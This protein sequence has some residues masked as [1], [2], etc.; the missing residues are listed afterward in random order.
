MEDFT[1]MP[2][3]GS[4]QTPTDKSTNEI[5]NETPA[6]NVGVS[7][8]IPTNGDDPVKPIVKTPL[9]NGAI[10]SPEVKDFE[11]GVM[12]DVDTSRSL[13]PMDNIG[14]TSNDLPDP[15]QVATDGTGGHATGMSS[16]T[17]V[18]TKKFNPTLDYNPTFTG[19]IEDMRRQQA[20]NQSGW[21]QAG[22]AILRVGANLLP[23]IG[24][25]VG[26]LFD[27]IESADSAHANEWT[28]AM[29]EIKDNV[30]E[31]LPIYRK[32]PNKTF[33]YTDSAWWFDNGSNV[34]TSGIAFVLIGRMTGGA[35][36]FGLTSATRGAKFGIESIKAINKAGQ[37]ARATT[38]APGTVNV[39]N[40]LSSIGATLAMNQMETKGIQ[41]E[42]FSLAYDKKLRELKADPANINVDDKTLENLA[43]EDA[44]EK[45]VRAGRINRINILLNLSSV[46]ALGKPSAL[47]TRNLLKP[48]SFKRSA[49]R[50]VAEMAQEYA[51]ETI[52]AVATDVSVNE[53]YGIDNYWKSA[54]SE[55]AREQGFFGALGGGFQTGLTSITKRLPTQ[56]NRAYQDAFTEKVKEL[57]ASGTTLTPQ[58]II[59]KANEYAYNTAGKKKISQK[60]A[61]KQAY[62][63]QQRAIEEMKFA[64][65]PDNVRTET[66]I[67]SSIDDMI[68]IAKEITALEADGKYAEATALKQK[69]FISTALNAFQNGTTETLE[70]HIKA[71]IDLKQED[72]V[73]HGLAVDENDTAYKTRA[74][75]ALGD[76]LYLENKY[77][78]H[79]GLM[80]LG[81]MMDIEIQ[82][83]ELNKYLSNSDDA[84]INNAINK[85]S[86]KYPSLKGF[87]VNSYRNN[88]NSN[89][90]TD[91]QQNLPGVYN[92]L[93]SYISLK[94]RGESFSVKDVVNN[95]SL[96][97]SSVYRDLHNSQASDNEFINALE[98]DPSVEAMQI[99][100]AIKTIEASES[101]FEKAIKQYSERRDDLKYELNILESREYQKTLRELYNTKIEEENKEKARDEAGKQE[102]KNRNSQ[103]PVTPNPVNTNVPSTNSNQSS[104]P[105]TNTPSNG[106]NLQT[107]PVDPELTEE[108]K[109]SIEEQVR[110]LKAEY[111]VTVKQDLEDLLFS[112]IS[113]D[114]INK[115]TELINNKQLFEATRA[116]IDVYS[117]AITPEQE[118]AAREARENAIEFRDNLI[119]IRQLTPVETALLEA[120]ESAI[121]NIINKVGIED[122]KEIV[123][124]DTGYINEEGVAI[125]FTPVLEP[126]NFLSYVDKFITGLKGS[127]T[128]YLAAVK[129]IEDRMYSPSYTEGIEVYKNT[130]RG[131]G[132]IEN[133]QFEQAIEGIRIWEEFKAYYEKVKANN[134][135]LIYDRQLAEKRRK[136]ANK[137]FLNALKIQHQLKIAELQ[138]NLKEEEDQYLPYLE[139]QTNE[140][141]SEI[142]ESDLTDEEKQSAIEE[143]QAQ[144]EQAVQAFID[145]Q[146]TQNE[147]Q[148]NENEEEQNEVE[149]QQKEE[150]DDEAIED[151]Y[152][153]LDTATKEIVDSSIDEISFVFDA[154]G[155][156]GVDITDLNEVLKALEKMVGQDALGKAID[157]ITLTYNQRTGNNI[158]QPLIT[159]LNTP[160]Y[161]DL[162]DTI[163]KGIKEL[164][165]ETNEWTTTSNR[166]I[167]QAL[168]E[169]KAPLQL[170]DGLTYTDRKSAESTRV[171]Y[172]G[173]EYISVIKDGTYTR[174]D[175]GGAVRLDENDEMLFSNEKGIKEGTVLEFKPLTSDEYT[176]ETGLSDVNFNDNNQIPIGI[177]KDGVRVK[178]AFLH[179]PTW[180][181][182]KN[183]YKPDGYEGTLETWL[184]Y[185]RESLIAI[186]NIIIE[187]GSVTAPV[188]NT[189]AG[190]INTLPDS[191]PLVPVSNQLPEDV[192]IAVMKNGSPRSNRDTVVSAQTP[193]ELGN[194]T[195]VLILPTNKGNV[196]FPTYK[197]G[198]SYSMAN[199]VHKIIGAFIFNNTED[200]DPKL[201]ES[202]S[203][204]GLNMN[205]YNSLANFLNPIV[206]VRTASSLTT[207]EYKEEY[208]QPHYNSTI[209]ISNNSIEFIHD[210][211]YYFISRNQL[212]SNLGITIQTFGKLREAL[213]QMTHNVDINSLGRTDLAF[214]VI[215]SDE[216]SNNIDSYITDYNEYVRTVSLTNVSPFTLSTGEVVYN[217]QKSYDVDFSGININPVTES[218]TTTQV[219]ET[220]NAPTT[221][222]FG[223]TINPNQGLEG[224]DDSILG[225]QMVDFTNTDSNSVRETS[226]QETERYTTIKELAEELSKRTG[227]EYETGYDL[228]G[229]K[230]YIKKNKVFINLR[231]ATKDTP[232]HEI[233]GHPVVRDLK[234]NNRPAYDNLVKELENSEEGQAVLAHVRN[235]YKVRFTTQDPYTEDD[236]I[237]EAVVELLGRVA[238]RK[239]DEKKM[240]PSLLSALKKLLAV[241]SDVIREMLAKKKIVVKDLPSNITIDDIAN[242][243]AYT[244][245]PFE[246]TG[247]NKV[248]FKSTKDTIFDTRN[249]AAQDSGPKVF[250]R[251]S[252]IKDLSLQDFKNITI[253]LLKS[254]GLNPVE[255]LN[256]MAL[257][258]HS[259]KEDTAISGDYVFNPTLGIYNL[260][261]KYSSGAE[262]VYK[263][264]PINV[265]K[266]L[267][268]NR[269]KRQDTV[270]FNDEAKEALNRLDDISDFLKREEEYTKSE[271]LTENYKE[272]NNIVYNPDEAF[273][274]NHS[275][276]SV[277]GAYSSLNIAVLLAN[278]DSHINDNIDVGGSFT[279][280]SILS[281][282]NSEYIVNSFKDTSIYFDIVPTSEDIKWSAIGDVYSGSVFNA[283]ELLAKG[284]NPAVAGIAYSKYP[285][286]FGIK[287]AGRG[288][289]PSIGYTIDFKQE[290]DGA[291]NYNELGV[292][293]TPNNYRIRYGE[294]I[295]PDHKELIDNYNKMLDEKYGE[296][297]KPIVDNVIKDYITPFNK[298][299][300]SIEEIEKMLWEEDNTLLS[301]PE[302]F[303]NT[304]GELIHNT[305]EGWIIETSEGDKHI[306]FN[307]VLK[308]LQ[309]TK[310]IKYSGRKKLE[311]NI[312]VVELKNKKEQYNRPYSEMVILAS[313]NSKLLIDSVM[314]Q[315]VETTPINVP[316]LS[317]IVLQSD[318]QDILTYFP[319][320]NSNEVLKYLES[321]KI[322]ERKCQ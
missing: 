247:V 201:S 122:V 42:T 5:T 105:N 175:I 205:S 85:L 83:L 26:N 202:L 60:T 196:A 245:L 204:L 86:E 220:N 264:T 316:V 20:V 82:L 170:V 132:F 266:K 13:P 226:E 322:V 133:A 10:Y 8:I 228:A 125:D 72:A 129:G 103:E 278:L 263:S 271:I 98:N 256:N 208:M 174:N 260:T 248:G 172:L 111:L 74:K 207:E 67:F 84:S 24:Q 268:T 291:V 37:M 112:G 102:N 218:N 155:E 109:E 312:K 27:T 40:T 107:P 203:Q 89:T 233:I 262:N 94:S 157:L 113:D 294:Q 140:S 297:K 151:V 200:G 289:L 232:I 19:T 154:L 285:S 3:N 237:E 51:E 261:I 206:N 45:T 309:D 22:N 41:T 222:V 239:I 241:I 2:N 70:G 181:N 38:L 211:E 36:N 66:T 110:E 192:Q 137:E 58:E 44:V 142:E 219:T 104:Q 308:Q 215:S 272:Y 139:A 124:T 282:N 250:D 47:T 162:V 243:I 187:Q 276:I 7:P 229:I 182:H 150:E 191:S 9:F 318:I 46:A 15:W 193:F 189:T 283:P 160:E 225:F 224:L 300:K 213:S 30:N 14:V 307:T 231:Y 21:N 267:N 144:H 158:T 73:T 80:D 194:G 298:E 136:E 147:A 176:A 39:I 17:F 217:V 270:P 35:I 275:F 106:N 236:I 281:D 55:E 25:Q 114:V 320:S 164:T 143:I 240:N 238:S 177:F 198:L 127:Y 116:I 159:Y 197:S 195:P 180:V 149:S 121:H 301:I 97:H 88:K 76:L 1:Y 249:E 259:T 292:N 101:Y 216:T 212:S 52:N 165:Y 156:R 145:Y 23:E 59:I 152:N 199:T 64:L 287:E 214:P 62:E 185:Q 280:S 148:E 79:Y 251:D 138:V 126:I 254:T 91:L 173:K 130:P 178:G 166:L 169:A 118:K 93:E 303:H 304:Y 302:T 184:E 168:E 131:D 95:T 128:E 319:D 321:N 12:A 49:G 123:Y 119:A 77:N 257:A 115:I 65:S 54:M 223:Q 230:G 63:N 296:F 183:M 235:L 57:G 78:S 4:N 29:Q 306:N 295:D 6:S 221:N 120:K 209:K 293:L 34:V 299:L 48:P 288:L 277:I 163:N 258:M 252:I 273:S 90:Y 279:I 135:K 284:M 161:R 190:V 100:D 11:V 167:D 310:L 305:P 246:I 146:K 56:Q 28:K 315:K 253:D 244:N 99:L 188:Y 179:L 71:L 311:H 16:E 265:L 68:T 314:Y 31:A 290:D 69:N 33:D 75:E 186:R 234:D 227:I 210:G 96:I 43:K 153:N 286:L 53:L 61:E 242:L 171:A 313:S 32:D 274:R 81:A 18:D 269:L 108:E 255:S 134:D 141:L 117:L 317:D 92:A 50:Y 87:D